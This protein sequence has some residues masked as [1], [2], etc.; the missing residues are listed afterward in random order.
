MKMEL[1]DAKTFRMLKRAAEQQGE[2]LAVACDHCGAPPDKP[3]MSPQFRP[4]KKAHARR[5]RKL[6]GYGH[7]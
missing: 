4:T 3:C 1:N 5:L 6:H 2:A 7:D